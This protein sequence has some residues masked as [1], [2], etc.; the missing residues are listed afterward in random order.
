MKR[1][2]TSLMMLAMVVTA[3]RATS[4]TTL[5]NA[6]DTAD[7][8]L[9][10]GEAA[11]YSQAALDDYIDV[12]EYCRALIKQGTC[13]Q[14]EATVAYNKL[15]TAK[16]T[17]EGTAGFTFAGGSATEYDTDRGFIHPGGLH[18][19]EDFERIRQQLA[20]GNELVTEAYEVL[21]NADY[22]QSTVTTYPVETIYRG[23]ND[24][25]INAARGATMA[26]QN[27]LRW[28]ISGNTK[29]ADHAVDILMDWANTTTGISGNSNYALAAGIYGYEFAQAA[30]LLH[31]YE[32]WAAEDFETFK[33]WMLEI[34]YP[35]AV[36][37]LRVRNGTWE[38][39]STW[40]QCP[41]HYWSNWGLCCAMCLISIGVLCDDVYIYNQGMSFFKYD[42]VGTFEDP[43]TADPI[44]NDGLTEF[45][46]NLVVTTTESDLET[47]A[48]GKLGQMQESGRDTGHAS[49]ACGLAVDLAHMGYNQGD[50]LFAFMDHRL[51]AGIE[52][53]AAQMMS[54]SDLPWTNYHYATSGYYWTD[55]RAWLMTGPALGSQIRSYWGTVIG[56]Y[57]G[58]KGVTMPYSEKAY[59]AMG[60]DDGGTGSTSGDYDHL[61]YSVLMNTRDGIAAAED[62]PTE[63]T[64]YI[65][66]DGETLQQSELGGL[67]NTYT[68]NGTSAQ[69]T[70]KTVTLW[71][72]VPDSVTDTGQWQWNTGET[73][74]SITVTTD[75]S[76]AYRVTYTNANGV[77]SQQ[78]FTIA[79]EGD[80][81]G[82]ST[83][84][85]TIY[86]DVTTYDTS[87]DVAFGDDVTLGIDGYG[88]WN[89]YE[90]ENGATTST[91]TLSCVTHSRQIKAALINHGGHRT[92]I[93]FTI[94]CKE[95]MPCAIVNGVEQENVDP[96]LVSEGDSVIIKPSVP[97]VLEG[98]TFVWDDGSSADSLNLGAVTESATYTLTYIIND[99]T[100]YTCT[101]DVYVASATYRLLELGNYTIRE[102]STG[103]LLTNGGLGSSPTFEAEDED[104]TVGQQW[105]IYRTSTKNPYYEF[106]SLIDSST[107]DKS[108]TMVSRLYSR[109]HRIVFAAGTDYATIYNTNDV[110]Y[111]TVSSDG[112]IDWAGASELYGY[113]FEVL[114]VDDGTGIGGVTAGTASGNGAVYDLA[115]RRVTTPRRGIYIRNG[116]KIL[117]K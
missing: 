99:T 64:P 102:R 20:D 37:F 36:G 88:G 24:N 61:G 60:I 51:A 107:I 79:A 19:E 23:S 106:K 103:R 85:Y 9:A 54:V 56:H 76:Y 110:P 58:V 53:V 6:V 92:I 33:K 44:L 86:N 111:I 69:E 1:L 81:N 38:N 18:T 21:C 113:P 74:Q 90:W 67:V 116:R 16:T 87:V 72:E 15:K 96:I 93:T 57:E 97:E 84:A 3:A 89:N 82:L 41:G 104:N 12:L 117:V 32:G 2:I 28:R 108:G 48:Y 71:A 27:A 50:D 73:T 13:T 109:P 98:G 34:W 5:Q 25:Y 65:L 77:K 52:Y 17:L 31:D 70:G 30:E 45:L 68:N 62:V 80:C 46:G 10:S 11:A 112:T 75:K 115:G 105:Y 91:I 55:S 35:S 7:A 94:N 101:F 59:A 4:F 42:Q 78:L 40:W 83:S 26:Y 95:L 114:A 63:L 8:F 43:R 22:A 39:S 100:S 29:F 14:S 49:M 47:G 66:M